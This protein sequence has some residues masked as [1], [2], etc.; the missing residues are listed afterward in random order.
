[1][2]RWPGVVD[3]LD[4]TAALAFKPQAGTHKLHWVGAKTW[5]FTI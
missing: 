3:A 1:M 4:P 2:W 5:T